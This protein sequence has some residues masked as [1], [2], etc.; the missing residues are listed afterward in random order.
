MVEHIVIILLLFGGLSASR[1]LHLDLNLKSFLFLPLLFFFAVFIKFNFI[2][3]FLFV[4]ELHTFVKDVEMH[5]DY[6][7]LLHESDEF[8]RESG[9]TLIVKDQW[10]LFDG[11]VWLIRVE[12]HQLQGVLA[13]EVFEILNVLEIYLVEYFL[14]I[15]GPDP[16]HVDIK[17]V[18]LLLGEHLGQSVTGES[19]LLLVGL[20]I[21]L[22]R[23]Q[24]LE[25][26]LLL[27]SLEML[28][29]SVLH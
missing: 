11:L 10:L 24:H 15:F 21:T 1:F 17:L 7:R 14:K 26:L 16:S 5:L 3:N 18:F 22:L 4:E 13:G 19:L 12:V 20:R 2:L 23:L 25:N 6:L 27:L 9:R 8:S 28:V 29:D